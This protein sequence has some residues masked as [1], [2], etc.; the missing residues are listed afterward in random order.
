MLAGVTLGMRAPW[1]ALLNGG[2][3]ELPDAGGGNLRGKGH[4]LHPRDAE[5]R[6]AYVL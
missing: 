4:K 5:P 3:S 2:Q 6:S 1:D